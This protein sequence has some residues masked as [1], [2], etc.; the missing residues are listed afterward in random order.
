M[1]QLTERERISLLMMRG[2][3]AVTRTYRQVQDL[4]NETFR[5]GANQISSSTVERTVRRFNEA[6]TVKDLPRS[7]RPRSAGN[8]ENSLNVLLSFTEDPHSSI[9]RVSQEHDISKSSVHNTLQRAKFHPFKVTLVHKL[10]EDDFDRRDEF[11]EEMMLRIDED[12]NFPFNIVFSD[13]ATFQ[14]DGTLNRHNCRYWADSNPHW[15]REDKSQYPQK[16]NVW[17]GI[18]NN[19]II[20]PFFIEGNLNA[21]SYEIM[22]RNQII[23][24]IRAITGENFENTWFQQ[25]GAPAHYGRDVRAYLDAVFV[26]RWIGRRGAIE[27]PARSPD[28]TPLDYFL[29]GYL[30]DRVYK[31]KPQNLAELQQRIIDECALIPAENIHNSIIGFYHRLAHCREV[32]GHQFEHLR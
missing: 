26:D 2:W 24:A 3:G 21:A 30:K 11:S 9:R 7:G 25:D 10:N 14:L 32:A 29:W 31:T 12:P 8:A 1:N 27:W 23:P 28:L 15:A 6:G 16:L 5:V 19:R 18:L 17:A 13:E 20:G 4:F 22:L